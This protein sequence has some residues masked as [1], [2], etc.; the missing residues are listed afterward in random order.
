MP[1]GRKA[2]AILLLSGGIDSAAVLVDL[3]SSRWEVHTLTFNYGQTLQHEL[4]V[5]RRLS[6]KYG[7][8]THTELDAPLNFLDNCCITNHARSI[9]KGRTAASIDSHADV[10]PSYVPF[11][12][13]LF[14]AYAAAIA[15][16]KGFICIAG[17]CNGLNS[18]HYPDDTHD[19][20]VGMEAAIR[21]GTS[22][23]FTPILYA[24]N[25]ELSKGAVVARGLKFGLDMSDTFSCYSDG[26]E[27]CGQCDSCA[28]RE[29]ALGAHG[30]RL[31]GT[32][33]QTK[34]GI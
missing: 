28:V 31:D 22:P 18:G 10:P 5:A 3:V 4:E 20:I 27:H 13:G 15:E 9:P 25:T 7:A 1:T 2:R 32:Y 33:Q 23:T 30:M 26:T 29:R 21:A 16:T 24:P 12:N 34:G 6:G 14:F 19:F 8:E 11:R 17:G